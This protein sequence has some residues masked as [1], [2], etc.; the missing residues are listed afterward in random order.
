MSNGEDEDDNGILEI[1]GGLYYMY[2]YD[3]IYPSNESTEYQDFVLS[4]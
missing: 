1:N 2:E 3:D 4:P